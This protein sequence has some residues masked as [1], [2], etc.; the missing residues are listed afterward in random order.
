MKFQASRK[1]PGLSYI[2]RAR[3]MA[4]CIMIQLAPEP[5]PSLLHLHKVTF[6]ILLT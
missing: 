3:E 2:A 5:E 1:L 6:E 4:M